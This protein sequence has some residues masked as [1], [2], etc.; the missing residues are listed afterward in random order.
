M[1]SLAGNRARTRVV[2]IGSAAEYGPVR[3]EENP[4]PESRFLNPVSVYGLSKA[5]QSQLLALYAG[6]GVDVL[7]ARVFNL[8]G[9]GVSEGLFAGRL[10]RRIEDILAGRQTLVEVGPL[11][12]IRDYLSTAEAARLLLMIAE[13]GLAGEVYHL[14]SGVPVA[15]EEFLRRQLILHGLDQSIVRT[16]ADFS[17]HRGYDV[18][19]IYADMRKTKA[20]GMQKEKNGEA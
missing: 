1:W 7:C 10:Q 6:R 8:Y 9:P 20:L 4:I 11:S 13:L 5:W 19:M 18:P 2:L 17:N 12:A 15:M 14:A 16:A 3:P